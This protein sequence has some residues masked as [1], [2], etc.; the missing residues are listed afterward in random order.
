MT[1]LVPAI[2]AFGPRRRCR[3]QSNRWAEKH[4]AFRRIDDDDPFG[5]PRPANQQKRMD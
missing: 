2:Y 3:Q 5:A 4:S 1:A